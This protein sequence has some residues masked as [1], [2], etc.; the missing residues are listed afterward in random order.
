[1]NNY[2]EKKQ[3]DD[4]QKKVIEAEGGYFLVLAPPGCGK[5]ELL[6]HR[7]LKAREGGVSFS[8]MLCLTF[9]NRAARGM[10]ERINQT[11]D[12]ACDGLFVGNI[13]RVCSRWLFEN[14]IL[15]LGTGIIDELDQKDIFDEF[16]F[17]K[18]NEHSGKNKLQVAD[19][20]RIAS[21]I[22]QQ[23]HNHPREI[24]LDI[25]RFE[26]RKLEEKSEEI[27]RKYYA[28]KRDNNIIDFDDILL[29][30]YTRMMNPDYKGLAYS[31]YSWIQVDEVQDLNALQMAIV[32]KLTAEDGFTVMYLGDEQQAIYSFMGAK[33]SHLSRL[34][35]RAGGNIL[36]L[37]TNYR[38]PKC[39]LDAFNTYAIR[40]LNMDKRLLPQPNNEEEAGRGMM[41][42]FSYSDTDKQ[43]D[44]LVKILRRVHQNLPDERV[45]VLVRTNKAAEAISGRLALEGISHFKLSGQDLFKT[46]EFKTLIAHFSV[47]QQDTNFFEWARILWK[48]KA[49][50]SY[51]DARSLVTRLRNAAVSPLDFINYSG[52]S[53]YVAEF[54]K[55]CEN[56]ELVIFDTE[57]TGLNVFED[58]I[59]QIAAIK[60]KNGEVVPGSEF[61][62]LIRTDREIPETLDDE[63]NPM[64]KVYREG[65]LL[66]AE[67]ALKMFLDY[68][69]DDEVL[70]H[71]V[72]YDYQI[73]RYNLLRRM[74]GE[75]IEEHI[76]AYWDSLKMVRLLEP[77]LR[78]YKLRSLLEIFGLEGENSHRADDDI[79]ATKSLVDFCVGRIKEKLPEQAVL[80]SDINVKN[81][82]LALSANYA[83]LYDH[84]RN[85]LYDASV[86]RESVAF[87]DE[88][89]A[90]YTYLMSNGFLD[91]IQNFD[92]VITFLRDSVF[93]LEEEP[94]F[95]EQMCA[96]LSD[97]KSFSQADLCESGIIAEKVYVMTV[98]KAKGLEFE[99]VI[100]YDATDGNYPLFLC[101]TEEEREE[102]ARVFYVGLS[103]ARKRLSILYPRTF[104][105]AYGSFP[106]RLTPFMNCI[107]ER[108]YYQER[109]D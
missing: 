39:L 50:Q 91:E 27:A 32:D 19:I 60:I 107:K 36:R 65:P 24:W 48:L 61:N 58:D 74:N 53:T 51:K 12:D 52:E 73:L 4:S 55:T 1:M 82:A 56:K 86:N 108:F 63:E 7:I 13:H 76:R 11:T 72:N 34:A 26:D 43:E 33:L 25:P 81:A 47:V 102:E 75:K 14:H 64:I 17:T 44:G 104:Q 66:E 94:R 69:G 45:G 62:I 9:T 70:G 78:A 84:T 93:S 59:I 2:T 5:T 92:Y 41:N 3:F 96:H 18:F 68:V 35:E 83:A 106:K 15:P 22:Y 10:R 80:L 37:Y 99:H 77:H 49:T 67:E 103:R 109:N 98:H 79:L 105:S 54:L 71:N 57:T 6:T 23:E 85:L 38:S 87:L 16:G 90:V 40:Q 97:I 29:R 31:D 8:D 95:L 28:Y 101:K 88:L 42:I 20:G 46:D 21:R 89:K 100:L 30:T